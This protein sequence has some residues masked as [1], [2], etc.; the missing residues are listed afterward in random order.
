MLPSIESFAFFMAALLSSPC[1]ATSCSCRNTSSKEKRIL[2]Y[3]KKVEKLQHSVSF[4]PLFLLSFSFPFF[5]M[6]ALLNDKEKKEEALASRRAAGAP[7]HQPH[8]MS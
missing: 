1:L 3:R 2:E 4:S 6:I 5:N 8:H 7:S